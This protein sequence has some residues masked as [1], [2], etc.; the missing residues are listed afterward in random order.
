MTSCLESKRF[1]EYEFLTAK[2]F[3]F[4]NRLF[5]WL[6]FVLVS[7]DALGLVGSFGKEYLTDVHSMIQILLFPKAYNFF[8][9][10]RVWQLNPN[11][12]SLIAGFVVFPN[13]LRA[14][15]MTPSWRMSFFFF[16][17][18]SRYA[19]ANTALPQG[20]PTELDRC[21]GQNCS[22]LAHSRRQLLEKAANRWLT[23]AN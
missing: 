3:S 21:C 4:P 15:T 7:R 12:F 16:F 8:H 10:R 6:G 22:F 1:A 9:L 2:V 19:E 20:V 5:T 11:T 23:L 14:P 18:L 13:T 17:F